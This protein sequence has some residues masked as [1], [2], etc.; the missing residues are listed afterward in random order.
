LQSDEYVL[1][2]REEL[3]QLRK[4]VERLK[5][6]PL[7]DTHASISLLEGMNKL[8]DNISRL[9]EILTAANDEMVKS[10]N[11]LTVQEQMRKLFEQSE[12]LAKGI[13]AVA[14]MVK[15]LEQKPSE[16]KPEQRNPFASAIT[17]TDIPQP[18]KRF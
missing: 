13:V 1:T 15:Q 5:R 17:D 11:D 16:P 12:K 8:N 4:E 7:G 18:P 3:D 2:P 6:N 10:Y 14:D 9:N